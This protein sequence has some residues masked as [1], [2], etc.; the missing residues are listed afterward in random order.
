MSPHRIYADEL[1]ILGSMAILRTF[2]PAVDAVARHADRLA[3]LITDI[4]ALERVDVGLEAVRS[5]TAVKVVV[6]PTM[7]LA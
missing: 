6:D 4:V 2:G 5:G 7:S 3:P 1:T